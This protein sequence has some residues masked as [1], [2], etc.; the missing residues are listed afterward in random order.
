MPK[1]SRKRSG[2]AAPRKRWQA[3]VAAVEP[4]DEAP[5]SA[6]AA[7]QSWSVLLTTCP[8]DGHAPSA[9]ELAPSRALGAEQASLGVPV[10]GAL[11]QVRASTERAWAVG[12][13][14]EEGAEP[15]EALLARGD[16]R[17]LSWRAMADAVNE[18]E[19]RAAFERVQAAILDAVAAGHA[20]WLAGEAF[21]NYVRE[22]QIIESY[23]R[24]VL[25]EC[26]IEQRPQTPEERGRTR[27]FARGVRDAF[28]VPDEPVAV[29][30]EQ[31][32]KS[33]EDSFGRAERLAR[34][35]SELPDAATGAVLS[36]FRTG[37]ERF[38]A[39]VREDM[40][41]GGIGSV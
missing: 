12:M 20:A 29:T 35:A 8:I 27:W 1:K 3:P 36:V 24:G 6:A 18:G 21:G 31:L 26:I 4:T 7:L 23:L 15:L 37:F 28:R 2:R 25:M 13:A 10:E 34:A 39:E 30:T 19:T 40:R 5:L 33:L 22:F 32:V 17:G 41:A 14:M 16:L 11:A 9:A 38:V